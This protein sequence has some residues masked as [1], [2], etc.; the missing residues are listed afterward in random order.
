MITAVMRTAAQVLEQ[1]FAFH[2]SLFGRRKKLQTLRTAY[3]V[4]KHYLIE[5]E[6][7][8]RLRQAS[9]AERPQLY[10]EVYDELFRR[11]PHHPQL[12][13][14][15]EP[16][17]FERRLQSVAHQLGFLRHYLRPDQ[18]FLEIGAGDCALSLQ[19][20]ESA[21]HVYAVDVSDQITASARRPPNFTLLLTDGTH[22]PVADAAVDV[23]LSNQ[24]MEHLHPED[25]LEQLREIYRCLAPGGAYLC[26]TP[27]R[28]YG[29]RDISAQ[30][31]AV[32]TGLH[33]REYSAGE[34]RRL[35]LEAGFREVRFYAG[36]RGR[37]ARLPYAPIAALES[38]LDPLPYALR[39]RLA[40]NAPLRGVLGLRVAAIK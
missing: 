19:V 36:G 23:A 9:R 37:F 30:F 10:R 7:A 1:Y 12:L 15:R 35:L 13:A 11:I 17:Y 22:V 27:N 40:D 14:M 32:A 34:L 33:L 5:R 3:Q 8:A 18:T 24:L 29:P 16:R 26:I 38:L 2:A 39:R 4:R 6:L 20:A 21:R 31:D 28:L 25:A